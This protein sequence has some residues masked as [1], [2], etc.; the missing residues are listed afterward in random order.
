VS[1]STKG[2]A[3][4][5][6]ILGGRPAF[7]EPLHVGRPNIG[8]RN[9]LLRRLDEMLDLKWLT[10]DGK[11]VRELES[12][13]A[14]LVQAPHA[15]AFCNATLALELVLDALDVKGEVILPSFTFVATAHA[16]L[17]RNLVPVFCDIDLTNHVVD[18]ASVRA[19]ITPRTGAIIGV[20]VWDRIC[21]ADELEEL[22][23]EARVPLIFDAAHAFGSRYGKR[24]VGILG[25]AEVFS[26]HATKFVNS[27][28]GGIVTTHNGALAERLR[29]LRNFGFEDQDQVVCL[30]T[31]AKMSEISAAMGITSLESMNRFIE[32]NVENHNCYARVLAGLPGIRLVTGVGPDFRNLQYVVLEIDESIAGIHRDELLE[33]L[34]AENVLARKYFFPGCH[35]VEP[36]RSMQ[37]PRTTL[38]NTELICDRVLVLPTGMG[39]D[40][41]AITRVGRIFRLAVE[42]AAAL[43]VRSAERAVRRA[44]AG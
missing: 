17:R 39:V 15:V 24:P 22:A 10:N 27:F 18:P 20:H 5:L 25:D 11:F 33:V 26:L 6:A 21:P 28:E 38:P 43:K 40:D 29:L 4:E 31:N 30:G 9:S 12:R 16:V 23:R 37:I 8:D 19:A 35:R 44:T 7:A 2:G 1:D 41:E 32:R 36:Y 3:E 13:V 34:R 42:N 14:E